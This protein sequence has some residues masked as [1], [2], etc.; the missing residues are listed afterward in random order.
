MSFS[1]A[2]NTWQE[3]TATESF[4]VL[5]SPSPRQPSLTHS[6]TADKVGRVIGR[7]GLWA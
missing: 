7:E 5:G 1:G 4:A 3:I 2:E 6:F